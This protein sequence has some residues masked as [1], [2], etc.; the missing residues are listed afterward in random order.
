MLETSRAQNLMAFKLALLPYVEDPRVRSR[1][2]LK[3]LL[4]L[5][6][7]RLEALGHEAG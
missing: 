2:Q 7:R 5:I 6:D 4:K 3:L 1:T